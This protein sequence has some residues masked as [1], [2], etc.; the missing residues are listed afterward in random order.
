MTNSE[1]SEF[2]HALNVVLK[3]TGRKELG[4]LPNLIAKALMLAASRDLARVREEEITVGELERA[5][6]ATAAI[7]EEELDCLF[8]N[9]KRLALARTCDAARAYLAL[10]REG[11]FQKHD[12]KSPLHPSPYDEPLLS[13]QPTRP[14]S[15]QGQ[16]RRPTGR[17]RSK[18]SGT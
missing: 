2:E 5:I 17:S 1:E 12:R 11:H 15:G 13:V 16:N 10:L 7:E 3:F 6:E 18:A 14:S 9:D 4:K 8:Q